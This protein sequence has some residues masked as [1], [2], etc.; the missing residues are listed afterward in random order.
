MLAESGADV[1][2]WGR[3]LRNGEQA[4]PK[5]WWTTARAL[6][7]ES[8]PGRYQLTPELEFPPVFREGLNALLDL[9]V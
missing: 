7:L 9:L 3:V 4:V 1:L 5:L 6:P 2:I 8:R